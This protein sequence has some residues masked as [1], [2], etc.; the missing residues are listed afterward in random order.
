[1]ALMKNIIF[2]F[3]ILVSSQVYAAEAIHVPTDAKG[4]YEVIALEKPSDLERILT[5]RRTGP[6]GVVFT[7]IFIDCHSQTF[8]VTNEGETLEEMESRK[9]EDKKMIALVEGSSKYYQVQFACAK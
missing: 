3:F 6:S 1:M 2:A 7:R 5:S 4:V 8:R 9:F